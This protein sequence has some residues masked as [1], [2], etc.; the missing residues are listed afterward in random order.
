MTFENGAMK[1]AAVFSFVVKERSTWKCQQM[2][3]ICVWPQ[4][5]TNSCLSSH[6]SRRL[7]GVRSSDRYQNDRSEQR[8]HFVTLVFTYKTKFS[9]KFRKTVKMLDQNTTSTSRISLKI[10]DKISK[11]WIWHP[12]SSVAKVCAWVCPVSNSEPNRTN[13]KKVLWITRNEWGICSLT[14]ASLVYAAQEPIILQE[15][16]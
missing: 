14:P 9:H 16:L 5:K 1:D 8:F 10:L 4:T 13:N 11:S 7:L 3:G 15:P 12:R 6:R 2:L